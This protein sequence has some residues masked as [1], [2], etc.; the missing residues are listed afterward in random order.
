MSL[1]VTDVWRMLTAQVE[2][3]ESKAAEIAPGMIASLMTT[4]SLRQIARRCKRSPTYISHVLNGK[5]KCS[6]MTFEK[7]EQIYNESKRDV[8]R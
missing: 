1:T 2:A 5:S 6:M 7:L 8:V 3:V 4:M